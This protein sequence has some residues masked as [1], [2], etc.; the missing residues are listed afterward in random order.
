MPCSSGCRGGRATYTRQE[1]MLFFKVDE[2]YR[3]DAKT[4]LVCCLVLLW[5]SNIPGFFVVG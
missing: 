5:S 1:Y 2:Y 4:L 3:M